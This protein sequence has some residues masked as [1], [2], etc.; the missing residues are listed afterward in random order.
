MH[1][2]DHNKSRHTAKDLKKGQLAFVHK[3]Q[4][5]HSTE[6]KK[7]SEKLHEEIKQLQY[8][9]IK[10]KQAEVRLEQRVTEL[11]AENEKLQRELA[12]SKPAEKQYIATLTADKLIQPEK[13]QL[14]EFEKISE[15]QVTVETA[16]EEPEKRK[17]GRRN[18]TYEQ[19]HRTVD[20][21]KQKLCRTC[22]EWK[23]EGEYHKNSSS[24]DG[25][26]GSCKGCKNNSAREYRRRR[27]ATQA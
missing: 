26:A 12:E 4:K 23:P 17:S 8:E 6:T 27:K 20:G 7:P 1:L 13:S 9:I 11:K 21:V 3:R 18:R 25:L 5:Q 16:V 10:R 14:E 22:K 15:E 19:R 24:K 2:G